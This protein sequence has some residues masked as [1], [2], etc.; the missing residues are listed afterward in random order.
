MRT[1]RDRVAISVL[2]QVGLQAL[3]KHLLP[4]EVAD[5]LDHTGTLLIRDDIE[6]FL[7]RARRLDFH[8]DRMRSS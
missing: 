7:H 2:R 6:D 8:F 4:Q 1:F 5:H 3:L